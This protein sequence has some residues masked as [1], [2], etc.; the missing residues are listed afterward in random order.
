MLEYIIAFIIILLTL[1]YFT[2]R[3][4]E[5]TVDKSPILLKNKKLKAELEA[6]NA[7]ATIEKSKNPPKEVITIDKSKLVDLKTHTINQ[8][9]EAKDLINPYITSD[10]K[11]ILFHDDKKVFLG[12]LNTPDEKNPKFMSKSVESDT[13]SDASYSE[14][15]K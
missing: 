7:K 2:T 9:R 13:I 14:D 5:E 8:F 3:K 10:G 4:T 1:I 12:C 6:K 15:Q 11:T